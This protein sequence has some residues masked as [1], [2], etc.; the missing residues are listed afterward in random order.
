MTAMS[1]GSSHV[2]PDAG[3]DAAGPCRS[4]GDC[5]GGLHCDA[6]TGACVQCLVRS[7]CEAPL[8]CREN[9][10]VAVEGCQTDA[11]CPGGRCQTGTGACVACLVDA[12]C[13][14]GR[15]CAGTDC[16][17]CTCATDADCDD[18][19]FCNGAETCLGCT[20]GCQA[21]PAPCGLG[22]RCDEAAAECAREACDAPRAFFLDEDRD[23]FGRTDRVEWACAGASGYALRSGDCAD[24]D[25][26]RHP[27][28]A[29]VCGGSDED[30]D[31]AFD[32][33]CACSDGG[34]RA[35]GNA[36]GS[37]MQTCVD[38]AWSACAGPPSPRVEA[39]N[40][41]DDD[42]DGATDELPDVEGACGDGVCGVTGC[43]AVRVTELAAGL[44]IVFARQSNGRLFTW[45]AGNTPRSVSG[46]DDAAGVDVGIDSALAW[47]RGG[48][49]LRSGQCIEEPSANASACSPRP[50]DE[51]LPSSTIDDARAVALARA[52]GCYLATSGRVRCWRSNEYGQLGDG[53]TTSSVDPVDTLD[54]DDAQQIVAGD[55]FTCARLAS[56]RVACWGDGVAGQLGDGRSTSSSRPVVVAGIDDAIDLVAGRSHACVSRRSGA[57]ECWGANASGNLGDGTRTTR[58]SPVRMQV[59]LGSRLPAT[60]GASATCIIRPDAI[61]AC[62]GAND[63]GELGD[64]SRVSS[65]TPVAVRGVADVVALAGWDR[66][67]CAATRGGEVWCWGQNDAGQ[68]GDGTTTAHALP[69]RVALP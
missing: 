50:F 31:G 27:G 39:C 6:A 34:W 62:V 46:V 64:G 40:G 10:C 35:C 15:V 20:E 12:D 30:C 53:T 61:V 16:V 3:S 55:L 44:R 14:A 59:P 68:L 29:E 49:L 2:P 36:C 69:I 11:Q 48:R 23:G 47:T 38:R 8:A 58:P 52:H 28:R 4:D 1:C 63:E 32:E 21:G 22:E 7:H 37:G 17:V 66:S 24:S 60:S 26:E 13:G 65:T 9:R 5:A 45:G 67:W 18:G 56:G 33:G 54:L 42:C 57:I 51:M 25:A 43:D 41:A 19:L